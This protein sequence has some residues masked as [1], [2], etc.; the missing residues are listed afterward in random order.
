NVQTKEFVYKTPALSSVQNIYEGIGDIKS[1]FVYQTSNNIDGVFCNL[2]GFSTDK[3]SSFYQKDNGLLTAND[4]KPSKKYQLKQNPVS[5]SIEINTVKDIKQI[6][7]IDVNG[8]IILQQETNFQQINVA[9]LPVG[10]YYLVIISNSK[11][12]VIGFLK[13]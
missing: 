4:L 2:L 11:Q 5:K 13:K 6:K 12:E 1:D 3:G 8:K 10:K 7:L 9:D